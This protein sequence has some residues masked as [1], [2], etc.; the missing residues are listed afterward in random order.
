VVQDEALVRNVR[1]ELCQGIKLGKADAGIKSEPGTSHV[2]GAGKG[3]RGKDEGFVAVLEELPYAADQWAL[4]EPLE[5]SGNAV[6]VRYGCEGHNGGQ[7]GPVSRE[8]S[9][10]VHFP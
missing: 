1:C 5:V 9:G 8:P 2:P 3:L 7:R 4:C 6:T 10:P